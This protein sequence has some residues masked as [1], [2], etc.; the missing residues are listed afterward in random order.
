MANGLNIFIILLINSIHLFSFRGFGVLGFW[1][2][3]TAMLNDF[4]YEGN[5]DS[6]FDAD[7]GPF[8]ECGTPEGIL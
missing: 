5:E 1:G 2:C 3:R 7:I 8:L 6:N 4:G